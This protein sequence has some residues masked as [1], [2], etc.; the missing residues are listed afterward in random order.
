[1]PLRNRVRPDGEIVA[2]A[3]R[4]TVYGNRGG[5]FHRDDGTQKDRPWASIHWIACVLEFKNRRRTLRQPGKFTEL[6]FLDEA[7]ALAAGHRPCFEC[8]RPDA[9]RFQSCWARAH[10]MAAPPNVAEMDTVLHAQRIE[11][12]YLKR[13]TVVSLEGLPD[14]AMVRVGPDIALVRGGQLRRW[15]FEGYDD[16]VPALERA[17]LLTPPA[18]VAV[19]RAGY[20]PAVHA[21]AAG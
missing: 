3:A 16:D 10:R 11:P 2:T 12:P 21:T 18:I 19:I 9:V 5:C 1:M 20:G 17:E 6:F 13:T 8:R 14:G 4:G 15:T 7:T